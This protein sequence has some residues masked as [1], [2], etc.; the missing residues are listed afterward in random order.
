MDVITEFEIYT[1]PLYTSVLL[2]SKDKVVWA[3]TDVLVQYSTSKN[4]VNFVGY[5]SLQSTTNN[6][7]GRFQANYIRGD[8][9]IFKLHV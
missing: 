5:V 6:V 4:V 3:G 2:L 9:I 1:F 7:R 8:G